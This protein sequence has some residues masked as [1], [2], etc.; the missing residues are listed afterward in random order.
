MT[1]YPLALPTT[2]VAAR[3]T[4]RMVDASS[5]AE[6]PF[7]YEAQ[8]YHFGGARWE[9]DVTLPPMTRAEFQPWRAFFAALKG[10]FGTFTM[11]FPTG[12]TPLGVATGTPLV[13]GGSQSG[14]E[15]LTDGWTSGV[16]GI[17]KAGDYLQI[18]TRLHMLTAD[19]NSDGSGNAALEIWPDLRES[20]ADNLAV[21]VNNTVGIF[22]L[23]ANARPW[24]ES[25]GPLYGVA[26]SCVEAL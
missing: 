6:S 20:P 16:T 23:A 22:R 19:A 26:F 15:L 12:A 9:A 25:E 3:I 11:G 17:M 2:K 13:A 21:V 10:R 14:S 18:G 4:P 8:A 7:T 5:V 24:D 1:S